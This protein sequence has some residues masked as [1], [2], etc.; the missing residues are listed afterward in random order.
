MAGE[1]EIDVWWKN[2]IVY[3]LD[4][5]TFLDGN[6]DGI[7]DFRGLTERVD[8]L[9]ALRPY[10]YRWLRVLKRGQELLL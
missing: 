3:C 5:E 2:A 7:D 9:A 8:Y 4:V 1:S 10:G 6:G